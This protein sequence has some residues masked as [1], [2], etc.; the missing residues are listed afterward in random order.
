MMN[1]SLQK[2]D[3][4]AFEFVFCLFN[5]QTPLSSLALATNFSKLLKKGKNLYVS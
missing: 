2:V 3:H 1:K 5:D 4:T